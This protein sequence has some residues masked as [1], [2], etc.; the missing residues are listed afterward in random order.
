[1]GG[2]LH[3]FRKLLN[4]TF[5]KCR[6]FTFGPRKSVGL[7]FPGGIHG[8]DSFFGQPLGAGNEINPSIER[9]DRRSCR[10]R[11]MLWTRKEEN[12][13]IRLNSNKGTKSHM[14]IELRLAKPGGLPQGLP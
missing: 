10:C 11:L 7:D 12:R 5:H 4:L 2:R 13:D 3:R 9:I 6:R 14:G 1:M 8:K